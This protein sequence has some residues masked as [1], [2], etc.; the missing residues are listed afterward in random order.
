MT[1]NGLP[2]KIERYVFIGDLINCIFAFSTFLYRYMNEI[3]SSS[4]N[5]GNIYNYKVQIPCINLIIVSICSNPKRVSMNPR[6]KNNISD[7]VDVDFLV[8]KTSI[9]VL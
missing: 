3:R 7:S 9:I 4:D 8:F 2:I 5:T 1:I 6:Q